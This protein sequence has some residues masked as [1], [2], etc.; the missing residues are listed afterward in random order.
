MKLLKKVLVG[1]ICWGV[2]VGFLVYEGYS[3]MK[4]EYLR[5]SEI[6]AEAHEKI[7]FNLDML[8]IGVLTEDV[9]MYEN[10]LA[11]VREQI[12]VISPLW[13][14]KSEQAEY[15]EEAQSYADLLE[16]KTGLLKEMKAAKTEIVTVKEKMNENYG[17]K[18]TLTRDK[19]KGVRDGIAGIKLNAENYKEEKVLKA[20]NAVNEMLDG[21]MVK[22][23]ELTDCI[24]T[25]YKNRIN[26]INNGLA[27][28]IKGFADAVAG[29]NSDLEKEF[30]FERIEVIK[31]GK[32][33]E[34]NE[35]V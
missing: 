2:V 25:C 17:N 13:L 15:L 19:L 1:V 7:N 4:K 28:K 18:D 27:D 5:Q 32:K 11:G 26:E 6:A 14:V 23:S 31:N 22:A 8:K 21:M 34:K 20:V 12:A 10:N 29:L 3:I 9:E 30:E 16:S 35:E 33:E 24:D